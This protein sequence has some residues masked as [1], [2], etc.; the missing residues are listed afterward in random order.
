MEA[1]GNLRAEVI[2]GFCPSPPKAPSPAKIGTAR[3]LGPEHLFS[4]LM[5]LAAIRAGGDDGGGGVRF[6]FHKQHTRLCMLF[7]INRG[8]GRR[9]SAYRTNPG[10]AEKAREPDM[11]KGEFFPAR[12]ITPKKQTSKNLLIRSNTT[13]TIHVAFPDPIQNLKSCAAGPIVGEMLIKQ[14]PIY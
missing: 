2:G 4:I 14:I 1:Y 12:R 3:S 5:P 9:W 6:G 7:M 11:P 8:S 10:H 13:R